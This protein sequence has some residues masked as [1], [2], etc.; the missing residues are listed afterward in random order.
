LCGPSSTLQFGKWQF[1]TF[2][3]TFD[4]TLDVTEEP[5][6]RLLVFRL[7]RSTF[8]EDFEGRWQVGGRWTKGGKVGGRVHLGWMGQQKVE[9]RGMVGREGR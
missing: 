5:G 4:V 3:G 6:S 8:M 1:L 7:V 2:S 9:G